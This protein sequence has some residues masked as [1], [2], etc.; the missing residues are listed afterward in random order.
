M[1]AVTSA[2]A[3]AILGLGRKSFDNMIARLE[4]AELPKGRQGLERRIPV[5]LLPQLLLTAELVARGG[6]PFREAHLLSA[7]LVSGEASVGPFIRINAEL[8]LIQREIDDQLES[9]IE[10]VVRPRRGRPRRSAP[11][12]VRTT[13]ATATAAPT[14]R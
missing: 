2:T 10:T 6:L 11:T 13:S 12:A 4:A 1:R 5:S 9:A 8:T 14:G 3:A 7:R